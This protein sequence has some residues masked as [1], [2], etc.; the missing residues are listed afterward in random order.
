[1]I[2]ALILFALFFYIGW[3]RAERRSGTRADKIQMGFAHAI[4]AAFLG[5]VVAITLVNLGL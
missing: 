2:L 5:F 1:M 4:P 3:Q